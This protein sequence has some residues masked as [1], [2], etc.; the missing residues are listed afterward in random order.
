MMILNFWFFFPLRFWE[1]RFVLLYLV[2]RVLGIEHQALCMWDRSSTSSAVSW[3]LYFEIGS[4]TET[5]LLSWTRSAG[6]QAVRIPLSLPPPAC[7]LGGRVTD[8]CCPA[9]LWVLGIQTRSSWFHSKH[10]SNWAIFPVSYTR[11][12]IIYNPILLPLWTR[13]SPLLFSPGKLELV[14]PKYIWNLELT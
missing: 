14:W 6:Q 10:V 8:M 13:T 4:P 2:Y 9:L 3:A 7:V 1:G 11:T 12:Q 5:K